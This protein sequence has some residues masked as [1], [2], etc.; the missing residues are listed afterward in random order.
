MRRL[1]FLVAFAAPDTDSSNT[2]RKKY[3]SRRRQNL[4]PLPCGRCLSVGCGSLHV[5]LP[6]SLLGPLKRTKAVAKLCLCK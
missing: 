4:G 2:D 6:A 5:P 1:P 3:H